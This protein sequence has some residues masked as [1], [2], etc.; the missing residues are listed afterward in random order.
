MYQVEECKFF[1][2]SSVPPPGWMGTWTHQEPYSPRPF[3]T[4]PHEFVEIEMPS[5]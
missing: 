4:L 1:C 2:P 3:T 5:V